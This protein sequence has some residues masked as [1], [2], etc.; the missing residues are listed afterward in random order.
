[1]KAI[2]ELRTL[3]YA[4]VLFTPEELEEADAGRVEDRL[5]EV[6]WDVIFDLKPETEESV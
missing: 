2:E 3:G 6:G 1:M 5:I 4:V